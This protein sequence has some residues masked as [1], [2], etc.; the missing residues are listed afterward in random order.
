MHVADA[1]ATSPPPSQFGWLLPPPP[2][3]PPPSSSL[4][5][6]HRPPSWSPD[7]LCRSP[8][9]AAL[10]RLWHP[11]FAVAAVS[12]AQCGGRRSRGRRRRPAG[13]IAC[14]LGCLLVRGD[15]SAARGGALLAR[16]RDF[17]GRIASFSVKSDVFRQIGA[18]VR[19][20]MASRASEVSTDRYS[21]L[22][23]THKQQETQ[24]IV[25]LRLQPTVCCGSGVLHC[26]W[27]LCFKS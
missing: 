6:H 10:Y 24:P 1:P 25:C 21:G 19:G 26:R 15:R 18:R 3:P 5:H 8:S 13:R 23:L 4:R 22:M 17:C 11:R 27:Q 14:T 12:D 16:K 20:M 7:S 2:P 9:A